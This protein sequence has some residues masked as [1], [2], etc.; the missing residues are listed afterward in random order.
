MESK[1]IELT[2]KDGTKFFINPIYILWVEPGKKGANL[3]IFQN[4]LTKNVME[5][6]EEVKSLIKS[7]S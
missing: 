7:Q 3:R 5:S 1:F 4:S 6:Y 2:E